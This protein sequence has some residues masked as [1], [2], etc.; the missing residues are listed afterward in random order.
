MLEN[1]HQFSVILAS[2]SPRRR[3]LLASLQI[4]FTVFTLPDIDESFPSNLKNTDIA[5][6]LSN[7]K[8]DAYW[9]NLKKNQLII[10]ADTIVCTDERVFGKPKDKQEA[11]EFLEYLSGKTHHVITGVTILS[12]QKR[13]SF[14]SI[15]EVTFTN[16]ALHEIE[17]YVDN[18][19]PYDKAGAYGI[20]EWIGHI[21]VESIQGSYF[22]VMGLP[23]Q[24][25]YAALKNF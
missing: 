8:A 11:I 2:Q 16:L 9:D 19:Q 1:I 18:F 4:P 15:T 25:L 22:N 17:F 10:T 23:V 21:G 20:Q 14:S 24:K 6:F 7:K 12:K 3:E 5:E 13:L